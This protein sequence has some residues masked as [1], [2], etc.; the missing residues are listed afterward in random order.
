MKCCIE[1]RQLFQDK[2]SLLSCPTFTPELST[3]MWKLLLK[4]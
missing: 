4:P 2:K 3:S 1:G